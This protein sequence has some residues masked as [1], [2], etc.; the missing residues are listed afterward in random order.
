MTDRT[1]N[2]KS[3]ELCNELPRGSSRRPKT[4][5]SE[6]TVPLSGAL[7]SMLRHHRKEQTERRL[8]A[9]QAWNEGDFVFDR[10]DGRPVDPDAFGAAFRRARE[11]T[12]LD[13]VRLH[14]LRH[15]FASLLV[16]AKTNPRIVSDLLGS[17][18]R[19]VHLADVLPPRRRRSSGCRRQGRR[20]P[21]LGR[22]WG[23][24]NPQVGGLD[25]SGR[26]KPAAYGTC[27]Y[28]P[29]VAVPDC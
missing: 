10:G 14:D 26:N 5:R 22:I 27:R 23:E 4:E 11:A 19:R 1:H 3:R 28:R 8:L 12:G 6:R 25:P 15:G 2:F 9:G 13:G 17:C 20:A 21:R 7:I 29:E 16:N 18:H 24:S